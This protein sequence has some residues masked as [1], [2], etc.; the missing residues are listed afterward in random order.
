M[1]TVQVSNILLGLDDNQQNCYDIAL[2]R[3]SIPASMVRDSFV[4]KRSVDA[5]H[6][7]R[8]QF[9]YTVGF[10]LEDGAQPSSQSGFRLVE[11]SRLEFS[12]GSESLSA[13]PVIVGFG[14]A[15]IFCGLHLARRGYRPIILERGGSMEE[16]IAAVE[17]FQQGGAFSE[18]CNIQFGEGGAGTFSDG[19]L[20]TRINDTRCS[21]VLEELCRAGAPEDILWQAKPHI[22]TDYLRKVIT[23]IRNEII[24]LGG[25]VRFNTP[26]YKLRLSCG[27][28]VTGVEAGGETIATGVVVL[29]M[30]HSARES[31]RMLW[32][33]GL[34]MESKPFSV[35]ARIEHLQSQVDSALYGEQAGH[36]LLPPGEY[37]LSWR[38]NA[39][40]RA[41]YTFCMC[42]GGVVVPSC[43]Q[44][45]TV[46]TNGM[47][48]YL[49]D[50]VNANSALVVSVDSRDFGSSPMAG[51]EFQQQ[52]ER[53]AFAAT[54]SYKAP[55]QTVGRF[56]AGE[57]GAD[58]GSVQ[59]SFPL[60]VVPASLDAILP[61]VITDYMRRGLRVM[62]MKQPGFAGADSVLTAPETRT[63]SPIKVLRHSESFCSPGAPGLY[64]CG[65]GC[66]YAGGIMSAAVDGIKTAQK[67]MSKYKPFD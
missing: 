48:N 22:G 41:V 55:V 34:P 9:N 37:Q 43:S 53:R 64:P 27:G 42:P 16:R 56:L 11:P 21:S 3:L 4:V 17:Q 50:G 6:R 24:S 5:R 1:F 15:G 59:P 2:G 20:T 63:S 67:I 57:D 10:H 12:I 46:V 58:W 33:M 19:K 7:G 30:G 32:E 28:Q 66:G 25:T 54:G 44:R 38:D 18:N 26:M 45:D 65:E 61:P 47:S 62:N 49:R 31:F 8:I 60:G 29:A 40:N 13:P 23:T 36:P 14:P 51:M 52:I 35:G 39:N